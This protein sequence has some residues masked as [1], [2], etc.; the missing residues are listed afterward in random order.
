MPHDLVIRGGMVVDGTG[1]PATIADVAIDGDL[2]VEVGRNQLT[3][4]VNGEYETLTCK[5]GSVK[6]HS[7]KILTSMAGA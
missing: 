3:V 7:D 6:W 1:A 4:F 5:P 2:V